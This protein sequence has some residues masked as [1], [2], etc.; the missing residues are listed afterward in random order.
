MCDE[1]MA[2]WG[3]RAHKTEKRN[4]KEKTWAGTAMIREVAEMKVGG[5]TR[6]SQ[7]IHRGAVRVQ[8]VG[9]YPSVPAFAGWPGGRARRGLDY[10]V[11]AC[12]RICCHTK[13]GVC[14]QCAS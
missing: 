12:A 10:A 5:P 9:S 11:V 8:L 1:V 6:L 7:A 4:E 3:K 13:A 2:T 14:G